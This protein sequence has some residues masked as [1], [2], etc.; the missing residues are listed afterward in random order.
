MV[1]IQLL[2]CSKH[3]RSTSLTCCEQVHV[4]CIP[5]AVHMQ[6][7][8]CYSHK[9]R[10]CL[11]KRRTQ[12][13]FSFRTNDLWNDDCGWE[14]AEMS[15]Q[16]EVVCFFFLPRVIKLPPVS[17]GCSL[18]GFSTRARRHARTNTNTSSR[19]LIRPFLSGIFR[20]Q[21]CFVVVFFFFFVLCWAEVSHGTSTTQWYANNTSAQ[22][23]HLL[24]LV[25]WVW[26][27][28]LMPHVK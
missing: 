9:K 21:H 10:S 4:L 7:P 18:T 26:L 27:A 16:S 14:E 13:C 15:M 22:H 2:T 19:A 12:V 6:L 1:Q 23:T 17:W 20:P 28:E 8:S 5:L 25:I 3:L 24:L 11:L